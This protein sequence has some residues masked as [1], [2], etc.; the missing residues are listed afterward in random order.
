LIKKPTPPENNEKTYPRDKVFARF[1]GEVNYKGSGVT[2]HH[3]ITPQAQDNST[4]KAT[5]SQE[6]STK[7]VQESTKTNDPQLDKEKPNAK[8]KKIPW[9]VMAHGKNI[10]KVSDRVQDDDSVIR[11]TEDD[12][13]I[14]T[15]AS[16]EISTKTV[17]ESNSNNQSLKDPSVNNRE[18]N[19]MLRNLA[20]ISVLEMWIV[21]EGVGIKRQDVVRTF[22]TDD[23]TS[24]LYYVVEHRLHYNR[25]QEMIKRLTEYTAKTRKVDSDKNRLYA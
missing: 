2:V 17:Q 7:T 4:I 9:V 21:I 15:T 25:E 18:Q 3:S 22:S 12:D 19:K 1:Y 6:I 24:E 10:D 16:Q 13:G 23:A 5:I 8:N 20:H 14:A 11:Q